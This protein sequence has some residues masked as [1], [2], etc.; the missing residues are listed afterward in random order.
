MVRLF[1]SA[2]TENS[3]NNWNVFHL[4]VSVGSRP[5]PAPIVKPVP[6]SLRKLN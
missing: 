3:Q 5:G 4:L 6:D 2:Q 1:G